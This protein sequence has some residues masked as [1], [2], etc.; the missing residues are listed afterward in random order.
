[1]LQ[2][3]YDLRCIE[4]DDALLQRWMDQQ[5]NSMQTSGLG[6]SIGEVTMLQKEHAELQA[7]VALQEEEVQRVCEVARRLQE[8]GSFAA[9]DAAAL[10]TRL[11][12]RYRALQAQSQEHGRL[13]GESMQLQQFLRDNSELAQW[14]HEQMVRAT[15]ESYRD[16]T[17][18]DG[19]LKEHE[20]Q[21][22]ACAAEQAHMARVLAS[23]AAMVAASHYD[24]S[25]LEQRAAALDAKWQALIAAVADKG[26][27]LRDTRQ[28]VAYGRGVGDMDEWCAQA[29]QALR[30]TELGRDLIIA[31]NLL[32]RNQDLASD[33]AAQE[34]TVVA[35]DDT[36]KQLVAQGHYQGDT[37]AAKQA[38][39]RQRFDRLR[40]AIAKRVASLE[41]SVQ[42][43]SFLR[44]LREEEAWLADRL[45]VATSTELPV[46][47][48]TVQ[49]A[50]R[51]H[52]VFR[53]EVSGHEPLLQSLVSE[54]RATCAKGHF[55]AADISALCDS[56]LAH[57]AELENAAGVRQARL[58]GAFDSEKFSEDTQDAESWLTEKL[59]AA[60]GDDFG[61]D[62]NTTQVLSAKHA[63]V[64]SQIE[65]HSAIVAELER[66]FDT[67][68]RTQRYVDI[69]AMTAR[70]ANLQ[71]M[72]SV[73][74]QACTERA[75]RL[76]A[77]MVFHELSREV[78]ETA[79]WVAE[80]LA[81]AGSAE[82]GADQ[83]ACEQLL[84]KF[85]NFM[86]EVSSHEGSRI[87]RLVDKADQYL[88]DHHPDSAMILGL[89]AEVLALWQ[90][91]QDACA[92]RRALLRDAH[93]I[94]T[95]NLHADE[96]LTWLQ[97][98]AAIAA[99]DDVGRDAA[100][101]EALQ[102]NHL[103]F[104]AG[105]DALAERV[106]GLDAESQRLASQFPPQADNID[107]KFAGVRDAWESLQQAS[108]ARK[109][110]LRE[111]VDLQSFAATHRYIMSWIRTMTRQLAAQTLA[112]DVAGAVL[113]LQTHHTYM[114]EIDARKDMLTAFYES[115][116][117]LIDAQQVKEKQKIIISL[118]LRLGE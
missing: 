17:N 58:E 115:G 23:A 45:A 29:E 98:K 63:L 91:L 32:K 18:L 111:S 31:Q 27:K 76:Q 101:A 51:K 21:E 41:E 13:L 67:I 34:P 97:E 65:S 75:A 24:A 39:L 60:C 86:Q 89:R 66:R 79:A 102:R 15:D 50:L 72:Q 38:A 12:E 48:I 112:K 81:V 2:D 44:N 6:R 105:L 61:K 56:L 118:L 74:E 7:R 47:S 36:A 103:V 96:A 64:Q 52:G 54:G 62:E 1:M 25:N 71:E 108:A 85:D 90:R 113:V 49:N 93:E 10:E 33:Y 104:E 77:R 30:T 69:P 20:A 40:P 83:E 43:Q 70:L 11:R 92:A 3:N 84:K 95:F 78:A 80:K 87:T 19:K 26:R 73:A 4:R 94:H 109:Q 16:P 106:R 68:T 114:R 42:Y 59:P 100:S 99:N 35:L 22:E 8:S 53:G 116:Q 88:A 9:A 46:G 107:R 110:L 28:M 55:A 37:I 5:D 82:I 57:Y 117:R 14:I